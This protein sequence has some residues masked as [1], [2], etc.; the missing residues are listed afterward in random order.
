MHGI[1]IGQDFFSQIG[2]PSTVASRGESIGKQQIQ[3]LEVWKEDFVRYFPNKQESTYL[4]IRD[5][6]NIVANPYSSFSFASY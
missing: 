5:E 6:M 4:A 2:S 1:R 3:P